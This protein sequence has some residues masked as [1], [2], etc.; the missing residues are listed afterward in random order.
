MGVQN[1]WTL[2][3][4][5]R[6]SKCGENLFRNVSDLKIT[7]ASEFTGGGL[8]ALQKSMK[9][10]PFYQQREDFTCALCLQHHTNST[11]Q[12]QAF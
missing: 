3:P 2:T 6:G 9:A 5:S 11:Q 12:S 8:L 1:R 10:L 4:S 7:T